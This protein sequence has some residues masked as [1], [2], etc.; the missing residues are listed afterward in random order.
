MKFLYQ[1]L[2]ESSPGMK[3]VKFWI[4]QLNDDIVEHNY[5]L[6]H[7]KAFDSIPA[8]LKSTVDVDIQ[9]HTGVVTSEL[10]NYF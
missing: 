5:L 4:Q 6:L 10:S 1:A 9:I 2:F 7:K 3:S 8:L